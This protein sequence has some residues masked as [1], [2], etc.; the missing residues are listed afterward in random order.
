MRRRDF[1]MKRMEKLQIHNIEN[2]ADESVGEEC[3]EHSD[4]V[5]FD[6]H[7]RLGGFLRIATWEDE[8]ISCY[9]ERNTGNN[10]NCKEEK[11]S[12]LPQKVDDC[13]G[14][15]QCTR[16]D[17]S[18]MLHGVQLRQIDLKSWAC[19]IILSLSKYKISKEIHCDD[20]EKTK[21]GEKRG[22]RQSYQILWK[23]PKICKMRR[24]S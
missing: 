13:C 11:F 19:E 4:K 9:Q 21:H 3:N 10:G 1:I 17:S 6:N 23:K 22:L 8:I 5:P 20:K 16:I 15:I 14:S 18:R 12:D 2:D 24:I 7:F